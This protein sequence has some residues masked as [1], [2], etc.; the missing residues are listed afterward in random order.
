MW[1]VA[2]I[3]IRLR[4][5]GY[6]DRKEARNLSRLFGC[7]RVVANDAIRAR[8]AA[9]ALGWPAP[10]RSVLSRELITDAKLTADR[11]FLGEVSAVALQQA[12]ADL[13]RA[14]RDF[15]KS[16]K[17]ERKGRRLGAPRLKSRR[18]RRQ[19]ARFTRNARFKILPGRSD[20]EAVLR[21]PKV[22]DIRFVMSRPLP[23]IPSSVT[24]IR[25]ADGRTYLSFV[26][27]VAD[28][29]A[30]AT[31]RECGIDLGLSAFATILTTDE[32]GAERVAK[33]KTP[34]FLR[35]RARALRRSQRSLSRRQKGSKNRDKARQ[36]VAVAHRKV[37]D[38]RLDHAH[39]TAARIIAAH[40]TICVEDLNVAGI[41][42]GRTAKSASDQAL[43]QF[44]RVLTEK[45]ER[46]GRTIV[47]VDRFFPST[48]LCSHCGEQ[49][50]PRG[51][52]D[53]RVRH[54]TCSSCGAS[55]ARDVN[56][57]RNLLTEGFRTLHKEH[58]NPV[59]AGRAETLN[60]SG[61]RTSDTRPGAVGVEPG[62]TTGEPSCLAA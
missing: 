59:A 30:V 47:R 54:W 43:G 10:P 5:R 34:R 42:R 35:R 38:A 48:Q 40:D 44:L 53:L 33:V 22:G 18:D 25:E 57:A 7:C 21:L 28:R 46:Q 14:Y 62:R 36:K 2:E 61:S 58:P 55:H 45:A 8:Q 16:R 24:V 27:T 11:A 17:G 37:R 32:A 51:R 56:A 12:L 9:R 29:P 20:R 4:Y 23:S 41:A 1:V 52:Q 19:T 26:C 60:A 49:T 39:Q 6:P 15:F 3:T 31:G 13:D 50:G